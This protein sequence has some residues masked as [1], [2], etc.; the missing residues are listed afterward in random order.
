MIKKLLALVA[1]MGLS[2]TTGCM[3][4]VEAEEIEGEAA[5]A[6][7]VGEAEEAL[8]TT[9]SCTID[10]NLLFQPR[11][12]ITNNSPLAV[13]FDGVINFTVTH[14]GGYSN[15]NGSEDGPL[16]KNA[17]MFVPLSYG[18]ELEANTC[19]ASATWD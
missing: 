17:T 4:P 8:G 12:K 2:A 1:M 18:W 11:A 6:E 14:F 10:W 16:A 5:E 3:A 15:F 13:P 19:T 7:A 9:L